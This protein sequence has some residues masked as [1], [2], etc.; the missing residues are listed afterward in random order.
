MDYAQLRSASLPWGYWLRVLSGEG[1][2]LLLDEDGSRWADVRECFWVKRL[3]FSAQAEGAK[4][5][6]LDFMLNV[7]VAAEGRRMSGVAT[8]FDLFSD[9]PLE[10]SFYRY[11]LMSVGLL[12]DGGHPGF[13]KT[14]V[15]GQAVLLMLMASRETR[16]YQ[17]R[18]DVTA[19][20]A[21]RNQG[22]ADLPQLD[23]I[24]AAEEL[25]RRQKRAFVREELGGEP[26]VS[27]IV[28]DGGGRIPF[29]RT[30]W[31]QAFS[32]AD[33]RDDFYLWLV[34]RVDRWD[35]WCDMAYHRGGS[36]LTQRLLA[37][38]VAEG[39]GNLTRATQS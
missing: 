34:E 12:E 18:L 28:R 37:M 24:E 38:V 1:P 11:W 23:L 16:S 9:G 5:T 10:W 19:Y 3:G 8:A 25:S 30:V 33:S 21:L 26:L 31:T 39:G 6:T 27:L 29:S 2:K 35:A 22:G 15:E 7:L 36:T 13:A 32:D 17:P 4:N 14:T 20:R